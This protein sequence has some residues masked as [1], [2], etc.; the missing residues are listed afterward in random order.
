M[1]RFAAWFLQF[2]LSL[3][4]SASFAADPSVLPATQAS[5]DEH[6]AQTIAAAQMARRDRKFAGEM[7]QS[8]QNLPLSAFPKIDASKKS[9][10]EEAAK[11]LPAA[12]S[13]SNKDMF[14]IYRI[15]G[16]EGVHWLC[17]KGLLTE[18]HA[19]A[20]GE[21]R[22][23]LNSEILR[24]IT[25][26]VGKLGVNNF[27][28][29]RTCRSDLDQTFYAGS[30]KFTPEQLI[31]MY[32]K[33]F[34]EK[35]K[36]AVGEVHAEHYSPELIELTNFDSS[37]RF[38]DWRYAKDVGIFDCELKR[39]HKEIGATKEAYKL[40]GAFRVN[41]DLSTVN[42]KE[43][44]FTEMERKDA[45]DPDTGKVTASHITE[46]TGNA[47]KYAYKGV[48]P[49]L[50]KSHGAGVAIGNWYFHKYHG[51]GHDP[52]EQAKYFQRCLDGGYFVTTQDSSELRQP[53][54]FASR[55][56]YIKQIF[57]QDIHQAKL[58]EFKMALA[59]AEKIRDANKKKKGSAV[60]PDSH[61][62]RP[63][64]LQEW[65][66]EMVRGSPTPWE[67]VVKVA[68]SRYSE[69]KTTMMTAVMIKSGPL[70]VSEWMELPN[71]PVLCEQKREAFAKRYGMDPSKLSGENLRTCLAMSNYR[72]IRTIM[73]TL[74][75]DDHILLNK[76]IES[77]PE[78]HRKALEAVRRSVQTERKLRNA[79]PAAPY[80]YYEQLRADFDE[81]K[82]TLK[83]DATWAK[84]KI[85]KLL[86]DP[87]MLAKE[88]GERVWSDLKEEIKSKY[89]T[90]DAQAFD[91]L[92]GKQLNPR[93]KVKD[94]F[95][96]NMNM[97]NSFAAVHSLDAYLAAEKDEPGSGWTEFGKAAAWELAMQLPYVGTFFD[98]K[99]AVFEGDFT[100]IA[101]SLGGRYLPQL[102]GGYLMVS[103]TVE[104]AVVGVKLAGWVIFE[105]VSQD[106]A[107]KLYLGMLPAK[108]AGLL[109]PGNKENAATPLP[110]I[111]AQMDI[112]PQDKE[113]FG[114]TQE[115]EA[116]LDGDLTAR[117]VK[118]EIS[119][120]TMD[121]EMKRRLLWI[122]V[123]KRLEEYL[124][125]MDITKERMGG[126]VVDVKTPEG[127]LQQQTVYERERA[128]AM[129]ALLYG[130][131]YSKDGVVKTY[132]PFLKIFARQF[133]SGEICKDSTDR[134]LLAIFPERTKDDM[135]ERLYK[136]MLEDYSWGLQVHAQY[137][138]KKGT[139]EAEQNKQQSAEI[140]GMSYALKDTLDDA[141]KQSH[142][143]RADQLAGETWSEL[144]LP[145]LEPAIR[146]SGYIEDIKSPDGKDNSVLHVR[147]SIY[148]DIEKNPLPWKIVV[149]ATDAANKTTEKPVPPRKEEPARDEDGEPAFVYRAPAKPAEF[150][151]T[152]PA[153]AVHYV[154][155]AKDAKDK[156]M[157]SASFS[158]RSPV[159]GLAVK[160]VIQTDPKSDLPVVAL[161]APQLP[162]SP[163]K[164][165]SEN[166]HYS[167]EFYRA[168]SAE[169]PYF[170]AGGNVWYAGNPPV[171]DAY[172]ELLHTPKTW[173][174]ACTVRRATPTEQ[175]TSPLGPETAIQF[176]AVPMP[177]PSVPSEMRVEK[178]E[179]KIPLPAGY[180][181][182]QEKIWPLLEVYRAQGG[183][184][185]I[186]H[187]GNIY[188][189]QDKEKNEFSF[190]DRETVPGQ[191]YTYWF[192]IR[193]NYRVGGL[194]NPVHVKVQEG[195]RNNFWP[196]HSL[197]EETNPSIG[198]AWLYK[199]EAVT[200]VSKGNADVPA[201]IKKVDHSGYPP[202]VLLGVFVP[203]NTLAKDSATVFG[204]S[205]QT[206]F[207][208]PV[209]GWL[210][211]VT[212]DVNDNH[213]HN[214]YE[215][216]VAIHPTD[217][218]AVFGAVPAPKIS[219]AQTGRQ[220]Y[221][222][223]KPDYS[224][225]IGPDFE[226]SGVKAQLYVA[227]SPEGPW[228]L[229]PGGGSFGAT[230][231]DLALPSDGACLGETLYF[232]ERFRLDGLGHWIECSSPITTCTVP[233]T[234]TV[235][236]TEAYGIAEL[237]L[238]AAASYESGEPEARIP[239]KRGQSV[240][241]SA[242]GKW[243]VYPIADMP[244]CGIEGL[245][246][247]QHAKEVVK[248]LSKLA[249]A[250]AK[251]RPND[252]YLS[253]FP[254]MVEA[255]LIYEAPL[256]PPG[257]LI[258]RFSPTADLNMHVPPDGV[259]YD[260]QA[261][262]GNSSFTAP[263]DGILLVGPNGPWIAALSGIGK[264]R[265]KLGPGVKVQI[266]LTGQGQSTRFVK[267][268]F[269]QPA[270]GGSPDQAAVPTAVPQQ[271][272]PQAV[273]TTAQP[274]PQAV[275][276]PQPQPQA[277]AAMLPSDAAAG[278]AQPA[279]VVVFGET[280]GTA[281]Q[282]VSVVAQPAQAVVSTEPVV[283]QPAVAVAPGV[284][285][286]FFQT[287]QQLCEA[288][289]AAF[290]QG[291]FNAAIADFNAALAQDSNCIR[292]F[293]SRGYNYSWV[294]NYTQAI[295]DYREA[296]VR[297]TNQEDIKKLRRYFAEMLILTGDLNGADLVLKDIEA[298]GQPDSWGS[299][300]RGQYFLKKGETIPAGVSFAAA[301]ILD[302]QEP[303]KRYQEAGD[304]ANRGH[305]DR[306]LLLYDTVE[307][308]QP[309]NAGV[310]YGRGLV[311]QKMGR[312]AEAIAAFKRYLEF[313]SASEWAN[314]ARAAI[315]E[316]GK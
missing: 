167:V 75:R 272:Q 159:A 136:R 110:S 169:G 298:E 89:S 192:A 82:G 244:D 115:E 304:W 275:T 207:G 185:R 74:D 59:V 126:T 170:K 235:T 103:L 191:T 156:P 245:S 236:A 278:P 165:G 260:A 131:D 177:R 70:L 79:P 53:A 193:D 183:S 229:F 80:P 251:Q 211:F 287:P 144:G 108:E 119:K 214:T 92:T 130:G 239:L 142:D 220:G 16:P 63:E 65:A 205:R 173:Y 105:P 64:M 30:D 50:R 295:A 15:A 19:T 195:V 11:K 36:E 228:D 67:D 71:D 96:A 85:E 212:N 22:I 249:K 217:Q 116:D 269:I 87:K 106:M 47:L 133:M 44:T 20:L 221:W 84:W 1:K 97:A 54:D 271:P 68:E 4:A 161:T 48:K 257:A 247:A 273:A 29:G 121:V 5:Q 226:K 132:P 147:T 38:P 241:M 297:M 124:E 242:A 179:F 37:K 128:K 254:G 240:Q 90:S 234:A 164:E 32:N 134:D 40:L 157:V 107:D 88:V 266:N 17:D 98:I 151:L 141:A 113:R 77:C 294:G 270:P 171:C 55:D 210:H 102:M 256:L 267:Q 176:P 188:I 276:F 73:Q 8:L 168:E 125:K 118:S 66:Q 263:C 283:S 60:D 284:Q 218:Y 61:R 35:L 21:L 175:T 154:V 58:R 52:I 259:S 99:S 282:P 238:G 150:N 186:Y 215:V 290:R 279:Q 135:V 155:S 137:V 182:G 25:M 268:D 3:C 166:V 162:P 308:M 184:G 49:E 86:T 206:N 230:R 18:A 51:T 201:E 285:P 291:N 311:Y 232:C 13:L 123:Q 34:H 302:Q 149:A 174:Y 31:E 289:E 305:Y 316:L 223:I 81:I 243:N 14:E 196:L 23:K 24:S 152:V 104:A 202:G 189:R 69:V 12:N 314:A 225:Y 224:P 160:A 288:G 41:V 199:G 255:G 2:F 252:E 300:M 111:L 163:N 109:T 158:Q 180:P 248:P 301:I 213:I 45:R 178:V 261:V 286:V 93:S 265:E 309:A 187:L 250:A 120:A 204:V 56:E 7:L 117:F 139:A 312:K 10:L 91:S 146:V 194:S 303:E 313:D 127:K 153:G 57:G 28:S 233:T 26:E 264:A 203:E 231:N 209:N 145:P 190:E 42:A 274:Q 27:G 6:S 315:A 208:A 281:T 129:A 143:A 222:Q 43:N 62:L 306:A 172:P 72:E 39:M 46:E 253:R 78:Q 198:D 258:A 296:F 181:R 310:H 246:P 307:M 112:S 200:L 140:L 280:A 148:G 277:S 292:A 216:E 237:D 9:A 262:L 94:F 101:M 122:Y 100:G 95:M 197:L 299:V 138:T 114:F 227:S 293:V 219:L 76:L 83:N 33:K